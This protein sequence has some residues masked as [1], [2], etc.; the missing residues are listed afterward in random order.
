ML[1]LSRRRLAL[2]MGDG[3]RAVHGVARALAFVLLPL[4]LLLVALPAQAQPAPPTNVLA[5]DGASSTLITITWDAVSGATSYNVY[6]DDSPA[7]PARTQIASALTATTVDDSMPTPGGNYFYWV[8]AVDGSGESGFSSPNSGFVSGGSNVAPPPSLSATDGAFA[9]RVEITW[10][11][12]SG[13]SGYFIKRNLSLD[14]FPAFLGQT[15]LGSAT[16][17]TDTTADPGVA[18][19][20]RVTSINASLAE[21]PFGDPDKGFI[22]VT[23]AVP[24][25]LAATDGAFA[26][27]VRIT[28][29]VHP[30]ESITSYNVYE[31]DSEAGT[32]TLIGSTTS[33]TDTSFD[34]TSGLGV[35]DYYW[36][37]A[38][39]AAGESDFSLP[40]TGNATGAP[41]A[42][43]T[44]DATDGAFPDKVTIT[45]IPVSEADSYTVYRADTETGTK[46]PLASDLTSSSFDDTTAPNDEGPKYYWVTGTNV[47]GE[48]PFGTPDTGF[49]VAVPDSPPLNV[50]ATDGTF[51]DKVVVTWDP[52]ASQIPI[53]SYNVYNAPASTDTPELIASGIAAT[54][55]SYDHTDAVAGEPHYYWVAA[56]NA[57][58]EGPLS[59][60]DMGFAQAPSTDKPINVMATDGEFIDKVVVTW[61]LVADTTVTHYNIYRNTTMDPPDTLIGMTQSPTENSFDDTTVTPGEVHY[62]VVVAVN[63][64]GEG[65]FSDP[66]SGFILGPPDVSAINVMAS[67]GAFLDKIEVTWDAVPDID[68]YKIYRA[69]AVDGTK[70]MVM[71]VP[72]TAPT[73][74]DDTGVMAGASYYYWVTA[75]NLAG[76]SGFPAPDTGFVGVPAGVVAN[77]MATDGEF[78]DSVLVTWDI[79][80]SADT[81][82]IYR[83]P[84]AD[85]TKTMLGETTSGTETGFSD[86]SAVPGAIGYYFVTAV[87]AIEE[88][89][90]GVPDRGF[91][92]GPF[93]D[94]VAGVTA[95]NGEFQDKVSLAWQ[96][97]FGA[98]SYDIHR[99]ESADGVKLFLGNVLA[100]GTTFDDLS[101]LVNT[102]F[103]YWV[104]AFNAAGEGVFGAPER[105]FAGTLI[106]APEGVSATDGT[107]IGQVL[108][109][110][111][112]VADAES[113]NIYR[114]SSLTGS[115]T[116][117]G[118]VPGAETSF[119]DTGA[120]PAI[121]QY[122]WVAAVGADGEGA[123][124]GAAR[125]VLGVLPE[126][127]QNVAA[128][129]G[130][131][132]DKVVV[133][134]SA[135]AFADSYKIYKSSSVSGAKHFLGSR[136]ASDRRFEDTNAGIGSSL[137]WVSGVNGS[138]EGPFGAP[139]AGFII[140][141]IAELEKFMV[142]SD[143]PRPFFFGNAVS[144]QDE[145]AIV[146]VLNDGERGKGAGA[147]FIFHR[148]DGTWMNQGKLMADDGAEGDHFGAAV[149][150]GE[151]IAIVGAYGV[152][153][154]AGAA[155]IF[156]NNG[157]GWEQQAKLVRDGGE[158]FDWFGYS[159]ELFEEEDDDVDQSDDGGVYALAGAYGVGD[160]QGAIYIFKQNGTSW[161]LEF[162][163]V[164]ADG[165][166]GD[167]F[168]HPLAVGDEFVVIGATGRDDNGDG[169][170]AVY[171]FGDDE[172]D[173]DET[174]DDLV[175][176]AKLTASDGAAG[177]LFGA[178][179][180][181]EG[182]FDNSG[183]VAEEV[184]LAVGAP[185]DDDNGADSGSVYIFT[186]TEQAGISQAAKIKASDGGAGDQ[187]GLS[188]A[189]EGGILLA[190]APLDDE[191]G[192][193]AGAV[194]MFQG[195]GSSWQEQAKLTASDAIPTDEFGISVSVD[196]GGESNEV[197]AVIGSWR[198][199][200]E[201]VPVGAAYA[202][203]LGAAGSSAPQAFA[204][205]LALG[206]GQPV[207]VW[208]Y[209]DPGQWDQINAADPDQ[210]VV[211]D[212][213]GNGVDDVI[214]NFGPAY[215]LWIR[216][217]GADWAQFNVLS[218]NHMIAADLD[219]NGKS[220]VIV[221]F[222]G[223]DGTWVK[224][225]DEE[226]RQFNSH[227]TGG[228]A[229]GDLDGNGG[230]DVIL[231][232]RAEGTW[233]N[234]NDGTWVK[235]NV[236]GA[237]H[238]AAG[239]LDG[240]GRDELILDL[241]AA[242][243]V[244]AKR[245]DDSWEQITAET[246]EGL[247]AA[248]VDGNGQDD[249]I[250][251]LG[252]GDGLWVRLNDGE[253]DKI[254]DLS[255]KY[256]EAADLDANGKA[257]IVADFGAGFGTWVYRNGDS[258]TKISD[259]AA[260]VIAAGQF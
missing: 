23:P 139:D 259:Q 200:V 136:P 148:V 169:S 124:G 64:G 239:D 183:G 256:M 238:M 106:L 43:N 211:A 171:I 36:V 96:P 157:N 49:P 67:D 203:S 3:R 131:F 241:G 98:T 37:T 230:P 74:I 244:W 152:A 118:S 218:A 130:E 188:V 180:A 14:V 220:E 53:D 197:L 42:I 21:G 69:A 80:E 228:M 8:T 68:S 223:R 54:E 125:G 112:A 209:R 252:D 193:N 70:E 221:D 132:E 73:T 41:P 212:V 142:E 111:L 207:G 258:W 177:D 243:G 170:G 175:Q 248:D 250:V 137:Y 60:P 13:A 113:Y 108:V 201:G 100:P 105:G 160:N 78:S 206:M 233:A 186:Y 229:V 120:P 176:I 215:G 92:L 202:F 29:D 226:W 198:A 251:D 81:Y 45:W 47:A 25:G 18:Y 217:N 20:Y 232:L 89:D 185:A 189:L 178:S 219:G 151:D 88:S 103:Y 129:D 24:T 154:N 109:T 35:T 253:W 208:T 210:I 222:G 164:A 138:G 40:D 245:G 104:T 46:T 16:S 182:K 15:S 181:I 126:A 102:P 213:D 153:E 39:N 237:S 4:S 9:D 52:P 236:L 1:G 7:A 72:G 168:G 5:G 159:V 79:S 184:I 82:K 119:A 87:N 179:L 144:L 50:M 195:S 91:A 85:G 167:R 19:Y 86:T 161:P 147:A 32:K 140:S 38:V 192:L 33:R 156:V 227:A 34:D 58:G 2:F 199:S 22:A 94:P 99:S 83:A 65:P 174:S 214:G 44:V 194:Y 59:D 122:Y 31:A 117:I 246:T 204:T 93:I 10:P 57:A 173:E 101:A 249:L 145:V 123:L 30:D 234:M 187:F 133:T 95:S 77:V 97:F 56:V 17:F 231:N 11:Q 114:A 196:E 172:D 216:R 260:R 242:N 163:L 62:Y 75:T 28:W 110:W 12:V 205:T 84:A 76:E 27:R 134:W 26:D 63:V 116:L 190:G 235:Q 127:P 155:Y 143:P 165:A 6:R 150:M 247:L 51:G 224:R 146:G 225:N 71:E 158:A 115:R 257:D 66:E 107:L 254:H 48:G 128:T 61:D 121:P 240:D 191:R 135:A 55:T 255:P 166:P 141:T 90:F 162:E 149:A